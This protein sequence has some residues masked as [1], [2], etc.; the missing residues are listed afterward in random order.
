MHYALDHVKC[1]LHI[2]Y[3][4]RQLSVVI[5]VG[6]PSQVPQGFGLFKRGQ[7]I[8]EAVYFRFQIAG[9]AGRFAGPV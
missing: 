8:H 6:Q 7:S 5:A 4:A 9:F 2:F 1:I 3:M